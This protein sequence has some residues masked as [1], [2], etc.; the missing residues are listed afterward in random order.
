MFLLN[1]HCILAL[2][3]A[4]RSHYNSKMRY[5]GQDSCE[6][7]RVVKTFLYEDKAFPLPDHES[8]QDL[9]D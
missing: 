4:K 7:N 5:A 8:P 1:Q 3:E 9:E 2:D 6:V